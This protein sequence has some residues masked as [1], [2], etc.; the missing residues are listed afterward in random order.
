MLYR[1]ERERDGRIRLQPHSAHNECQQ[2]IDRHVPLKY[3]TDIDESIELFRANL[4]SVNKFIHNNPELAFEEHK[5]HDALTNFMQL[6][7]GWHVTRSAYGMKT[8][9]QAVFDSER[10]GPV[11]SFNAEMGMPPY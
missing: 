8:A 4:W 6:H 7:K 9:W 5:A 10:A 2:I 3:L 11:V 1:S